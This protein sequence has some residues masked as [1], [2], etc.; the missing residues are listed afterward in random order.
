MR[1]SRI[2][3]YHQLRL[4]TTPAYLTVNEGGG[5]N[6]NTFAQIEYHSRNK[7]QSQ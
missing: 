6:G 4:A 7:E 1:V 5:F 3:L 2:P